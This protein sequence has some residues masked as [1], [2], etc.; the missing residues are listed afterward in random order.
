MLHDDSFSIDVYGRLA[1]F[2]NQLCLPVPAIVFLMAAGALSAHGYMRAST[3]VLLLWENDFER[4]T[5][6]IGPQSVVN[7]AAVMDRCG[8]HLDFELQHRSG[9]TRMSERLLASR[10][11]WSRDW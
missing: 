11:R 1:V 4:R 3:V 10:S 6:Q 2:A 8:T 5:N 7:A 9:R